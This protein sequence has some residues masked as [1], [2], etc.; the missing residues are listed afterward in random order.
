M[1]RPILVVRQDFQWRDGDTNSLIKFLTKNSFCLM[2]CGDKS[3]AEIEGM[4]NQ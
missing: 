4:A 2:K 1:K 3:G